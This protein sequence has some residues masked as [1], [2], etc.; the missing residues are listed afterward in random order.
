MASR[1]GLGRIIGWGKEA[2]QEELHF[3]LHR[4]TQIAQERASRLNAADGH[5]KVKR[6]KRH[7]DKPEDIKPPAPGTGT[8]D[9]RDLSVEA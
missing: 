7:R 2:D 4:L 6:A 8:L 3:V 5:A 9:A 1:L